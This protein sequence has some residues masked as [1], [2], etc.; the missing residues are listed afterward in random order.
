MR[1]S[2]FRRALRRRLCS[3]L[4]PAPANGQFGHRN[5]EVL[6]NAIGHIGGQRSLPVSVRSR[7][8]PFPHREPLA[9]S[10]SHGRLRPP[11]SLCPQTWKS[12]AARLTGSA[13]IETQ[14]DRPPAS[15]PEWAVFNLGPSNAAYRDLVVAHALR[16][17]LDDNQVVLGSRRHRQVS[18]HA[19]AYDAR[20]P[21]L[22]AP[23]NSARQQGCRVA[24]AGRF[25]KVNASVR[26]IPAD[27]SGNSGVAG[28]S[29]NPA[30]EAGFRVLKSAGATG[31]EPATPGFG[32]RS[33]H[34]PGRCA[35]PRIYARF[36]P[37]EITCRAAEMGTDLGTA[38]PARGMIARWQSRRATG[39]RSERTT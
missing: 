9:P 20:P 32:E 25:G 18:S 34:R 26:R 38:C 31:L 3:G 37:A 21:A 14:N 1:T 29:R 11:C 28:D 30:W 10:R 2:G 27:Q 8:A 39:A 12:P 7:P 24:L 19:Y 4:A 13:V 35:C 36:R 5:A 17:A 23:G 16:A 6:S 15:R 22:F 33:T